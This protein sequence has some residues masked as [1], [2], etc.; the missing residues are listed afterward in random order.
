MIR[1][2]SRWEIEIAAVWG[3]DKTKQSLISVVLVIVSLYSD[4][5]MYVI[6]ACFY[7]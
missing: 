4:F 1:G 5:I 2:Y 6:I 3:G 7:L